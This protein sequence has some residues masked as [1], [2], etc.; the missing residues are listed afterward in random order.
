MKTTSVSTLAISS[1]I[2][3]SILKSQSELV[4]A[5]K[6]VASGRWADVGRT[7]GSKAGQTVS[8]RQEHARLNTIIDTNGLTASRLDSTQAALNG[9]RETA[10]GFLG[11]LISAREGDTGPQVIQPQGKK[12]LEGLIATLN[13]TVSGRYLFAGINS[14]SAPIADYFAQPAAANKQAVDNA[15]TTAFGMTQGDSAVETISAADMQNFLDGDFIALFEEPQWSASWSS[16]SSQNMRSRISSSEVIDT[17]VNAN[18]PAMKKL[19]MAYTMVADL[20]TDK[21]N[22]NAFRVV[23]DTAARLVAEAVQNVTMSQARVG[24]AQNRVAQASERMSLQIDI[25]S[26]RITGLENVDPYEA[27]SRITTLM[28]QVETAYALTARIQRLG[29]MKYL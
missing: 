25:L 6:E 15:F 29:L 12:N 17:S 27:T 5:Q 3:Q 4:S 1:A 26:K 19:A 13:A 28:T 22:G 18:E 11:S 24:A 2:R 8:L 16:A 14:D 20:G 9:I 10:E 7:L 23:V 21:L